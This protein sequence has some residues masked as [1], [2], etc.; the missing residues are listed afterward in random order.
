MQMKELALDSQPMA[1][2][3]GIKGT[4]PKLPKFDENKDDVDAFLERFERFAES[5]SWPENQWAVSLSPLLSGK[6][7]QVYSGMPPAEAERF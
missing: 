2:E 1:S 6:D 3:F 5:Q 4:R 7:L